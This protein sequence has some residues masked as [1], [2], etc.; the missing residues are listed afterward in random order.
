MF[1]RVVLRRSLDGPAITIGEIAEALLFYQ[2][3]HIVLDNSSLIGLTK[4]I[5]IQNVLKLLALPD[6]KATYIEE[7]TG[8]QTIQTP[9][10]PEYSLIA[11]MIKEHPNFGQLNTKKRRLEFNLMTHGYTKSESKRY[12]EKLKRYVSYKQLGDDYYVKGGVIPVARVDLFDNEYVKKASEIIAQRMLE[13]HPLPSDFCFQIIPKG[14]KFRVDTNL[15]FDLVSSIQQA[16]YE[17]AG[18]YTPAHLLSEM[19][20]ASI[21][22]IFAGHYGGDFYTSETESKL[23]QIRQ[24]YLLKR[25]HLDRSE[26][27]NFY[28]VTL[29]GYPTIVEAINHG[30]RSFEEFLELLASARK[31]K[32]WLKGKSPDEKLI[33]NYLEDITSSTSWLNRLPGKIFRYFI[34]VGVGAIAPSYGIV[35][36]AGDSFFLDRL[37]SGWKPNQ[38]ITKKVQP[39]VDPDI[40]G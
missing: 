16:K 5:G 17:K 38:F 20:N 24:K 15:D 12:V 31:F 25:F 7:I 39:F 33:A 18:Q 23:I 28:S 40:E 34:S 22:L 3:V 1:E 35:L 19:L 27:D 32:K 2:S 14:D 26:I 36:S 8:T 6:I 13:S 30:E 4:A 29:S 21:S 9:I 11:F 37:I 10:G